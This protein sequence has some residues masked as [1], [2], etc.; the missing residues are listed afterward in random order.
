MV[1]LP[2]LT[3]SSEWVRIHPPTHPSANPPVAADDEAVQF[4]QLLLTGEPAFWVLFGGPNVIEAPLLAT[5]VHKAHKLVGVGARSAHEQRVGRVCGEALPADLP[6]DT[7]A[8]PACTTPTAAPSLAPHRPVLTPP[9]C[10][11]RHLPWTPTPGPLTSP[12]CPARGPSSPAS[13]TPQSAWRAPC[14]IAGRRGEGQRGVGERRQPGWRSGATGKRTNLP[15][16]P[17][18]ARTLPTLPLTRHTSSSA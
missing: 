15:S 4:L 10:P 8:C 17:P 7:A 18:G 14:C 5:L 2:S 11:M 9:R 6:I 12:G 3:L 13:Q 16:P 1:L